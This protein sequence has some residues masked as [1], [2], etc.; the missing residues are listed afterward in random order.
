[1]WLTPS[2]AAPVPR[3]SLMAV[4]LRHWTWIT[5]MLLDADGINPLEDVNLTPVET[6]A[7]VAAMQNGE[8]HHAAGELGEV[9]V[10]QGADHAQGAVL[11]HLIGVG[12][13]EQ[14]GG[15]LAVLHSRHAGAGLHGGEVHILPGGEAGLL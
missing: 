15:N 3:A 14:G 1:M 8:I 11:D 12:V 9:V 10:D 5:A 2:W 7:C 4:P 6:S 13:A